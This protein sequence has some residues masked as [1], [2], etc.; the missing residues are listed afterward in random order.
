MS[1]ARKTDLDEPTIYRSGI[2]GHLG[3]RWADW[4][5]GLT[6]T[7]EENGDTPPTGPVADQAALYAALKKARDLGM[8]LTSVSSVTPDRAEG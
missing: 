8:P 1:G 2:K 3:H 7:L 6:I 5:A 4:F